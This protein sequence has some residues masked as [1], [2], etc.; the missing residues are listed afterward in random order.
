[1]SEAAE[2]T[3]KKINWSPEKV[4]SSSALLI[5]VVSVIALF[6]QLHLAR[7]ENELI[8]KQQSASV[9]PHLSMLPTLG[10]DGYTM[11]FVNQGVGPA[12][13][14]EVEFRVGGS[15]K[16]LRSDFFINHIV[17]KIYESDSVSISIGTYSMMEGD[18]IPANNSINIVR[19]RG[20]A[21][22]DMFRHQLDVLDWSYAI[23]YEDVYGTRWRLG[24]ENR[25]PVLVSE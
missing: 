19:V 5:S 11:D 21:G 4:M 13:I 16:F 25:F 22:V 1:M 15:T 17:N 12:F 18:V 8:R 10:P 7:E 14:K 20:E 2:D 6:Y 9:L 24:S 3:K 23:I